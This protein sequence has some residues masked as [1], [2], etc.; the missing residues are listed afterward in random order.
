V[1]SFKLMAYPAPPIVS[2]S[3]LLP[4]SGSVAA[5][6]SRHYLL[7]TTAATDYFVRLFTHTGMADMV[8]HNTA[9]FDAQG[10]YSFGLQPDFCSVYAFGPALYGAVDS[11]VGATFRLDMV[12]VDTTVYHL[13]GVYLPYLDSNTIAGKRYRFSTSIGHQYKIDIT[14]PSDNIDLSLGR[15][16]VADADADPPA[17][18]QETAFLTQLHPPQ[19]R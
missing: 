17:A 5:N 12:P 4:Y 9:T 13:D 3:G 6:S 1:A 19:R 18:A 7:P 16:V 2:L 14:T 11:V 10:C 8:I 15:V